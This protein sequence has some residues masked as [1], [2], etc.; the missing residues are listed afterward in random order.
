MPLE[1]GMR[2]RGMAAIKSVT[3]MSGTDVIRTLREQGYS[4]PIVR[5]T[6]YDMIARYL[7]A[8]MDS[9]KDI[10]NDT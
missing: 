2:D 6:L 1:T 8:A 4:K 5:K 9:M 7:P 3:A 10:I